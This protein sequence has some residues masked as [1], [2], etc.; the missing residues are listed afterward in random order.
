MEDFIL[1]EKLAPK[2]PTTECGDK[3]L[4]LQHIIIAAERRERER[5]REQ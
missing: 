4:Y 1:R 3:F 5:K 2:I